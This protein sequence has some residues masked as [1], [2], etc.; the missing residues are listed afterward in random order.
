MEDISKIS[1]GSDIR[2]IEDSIAREKAEEALTK[3]KDALTKANEISVANTNVIPKDGEGVAVT[4]IN[5]FKNG[6]HINGVPISVQVNADGS[7][8]I[9][10][11]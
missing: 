3:A 11:G 5:N 9:N 7:R 8:K 10:F 2:N 1:V 4:A 6:F